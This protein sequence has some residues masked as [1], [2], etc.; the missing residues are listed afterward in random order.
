VGPSRSS[1]PTWTRPWTGCLPTSRRWPRPSSTTW[2]PPSGSK[3]GHGVADLANYTSYSEER[4]R[5]VLTALAAPDT[6]IV[7]PV[8]APPGL[9]EE[10]RYEIFHDVLAPAILGWRAQWGARR[11][12]EAA[13]R[14]QL[15]LR[16][17]RW[18]RG[19][20][21][22]AV[23]VAV[24]MAAGAALAARAVVDARTDQAATEAQAAALRQDAG[25]AGQA[26]V[27][28]AEVAARS[29]ADAYQAQADTVCVRGWADGRVEL[30]QRPP[31]AD[32]QR[33]AEWLTGMVGIGE[34]TLRRWRA[35]P[36]PPP[37][38][39]RT[40]AVLG[41]YADGLESY[42][43]AAGLL[44]AGQTEEG[45]NLLRRGDRISAD[46]RRLAEEAGFRE[47]DGALPL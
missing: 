9:G 2:S 38:D 25:A 46:Y 26:A 40:A 6:R 24:V 20:G 34:E 42:G 39:D 5:A 27:R 16:A 30:G 1:A 23:L 45:D 19:Q 4:V 18:R 17:R 28:S 10:P 37:I 21:L 44:A 47:C 22:A 13:A 32:R 41:H 7:R 3:I 31:R 8:P 11:Q 15:E 33:Y 12:A 14:R 29:A 35:I 43:A 36:V